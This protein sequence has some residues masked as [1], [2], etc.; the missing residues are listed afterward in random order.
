MRNKIVDLRNHLFAALEALADPDDPLDIERARAIADVAQ[1]I[2]NTAKVE[3]QYL[4]ATGAKTGTGFIPDDVP[5]IKH[6]IPAPA[7][8]SFL[9]SVRK[10]L[11]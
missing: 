5:D 1:V 3:V 11:K 6:L 10:K 7:P 9:A 8:D 4:A 2:V